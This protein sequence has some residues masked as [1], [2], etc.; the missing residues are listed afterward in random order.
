MIQEISIVNDM[1]GIKASLLQLVEVTQE[2][3]QICGVI[4]HNQ[5]FDMTMNTLSLDSY[6]VRRFK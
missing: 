1:P 3:T 6:C 4:F 2:K 5:I